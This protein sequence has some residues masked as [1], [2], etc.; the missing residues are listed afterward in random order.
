M[1]KFTKSPILVG[2]LF[3]ISLAMAS[4]TYSG[5]ANA[6]VNGEYIILGMGNLQCD[7]IVD[8]VKDE[9]IKEM[10]VSYVAGYITAKN[11]RAFGV[12]S[13]L[14]EG[15]SL[16]EYVDLSIEKCGEMPQQKY[17]DMLMYSTDAM[18]KDLL[19]K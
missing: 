12:T 2:V 3:G 18:I 10:L 6:A 14:E 13:V 4:V 11:E 17:S 1:K 7:V 19:K 5:K 15:F 16:Q 9:V 8:V